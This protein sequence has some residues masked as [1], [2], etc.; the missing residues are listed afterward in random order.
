MKTEL[1]PWETIHRQEVVDASPWLR[2]WVE[3]VR[4]PD[5]R[6][7]DDFYTL[8]MPDFVVVMALNRAGEVVTERHY[9]HGLR[10]VVLALPAGYIAGDEQ[11][12]KA[13]QRELAEETGYGGGIWEE[14]GTFSIDGNRGCGQAHIFL[15]RN[16]EWL[17][18]PCSGDLEERQVLLLSPPEFLEAI[19][20]KEVV[21]LPS[22]CAFMLAFAHLQEAA[23]K[24]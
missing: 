22:V 16:V 6:V 19:A 18:E 8:E 12:L 9:R 24:E 4:L 15:A 13:A 7:V 14:L 2:L 20:R 17:V 10:R 11:P 3:T 5:G 21:G 1:R 23:M